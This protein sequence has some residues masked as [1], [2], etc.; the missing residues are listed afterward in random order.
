MSKNTYRVASLNFLYK[1]Q[2]LERR[3]EVLTT[4]M[5][6]IQPDVVC[7][8]EISP[9]IEEKVLACMRELGFA[10]NSGVAH[11]MDSK[12][13]HGVVTF[14]KSNS[15]HS[16]VDLSLDG[17]LTESIPAVSS[18]VLLPDEEHYLLILNAHLT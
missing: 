14:T 12:K 2:E 17:F 1:N 13:G 16:L 10:N 8:Q 7:M 4:E 9:Q 6:R 18:F 11:I 15:S 3:L 5:Q